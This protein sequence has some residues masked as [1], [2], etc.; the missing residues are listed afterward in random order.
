MAARIVRFH[1]LPLGGA[2]QYRGCSLNSSSQGQLSEALSEHMPSTSLAATLVVRI[3]P[4]LH[5]HEQCVLDA[6]VLARAPCLVAFLLPVLAKRTALSR[7]PS[8]HH[9]HTCNEI[10]MDSRYG[11]AG[12]FATNSK[13]EPCPPSGQKTDWQP[14]SLFTSL[15]VLGLL[16]LRSTF[17]CCWEARQVSQVRSHHCV[18]IGG[19]ACRFH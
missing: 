8:L 7:R 3:A 15:V 10:N 17:L 1:W 12:L 4:S 6:L 9:L 19:E 18:L 16:G 11:R 5:A 13:C 14:P 2:A